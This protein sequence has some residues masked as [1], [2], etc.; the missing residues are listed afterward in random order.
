MIRIENKNKYRGNGILVC[1]PSPLGNPFKISK[2]M[3]R[4]MACDKYREWLL[5]RLETENP[6]SKAFFTLLSFY[7]DEGELV[8]ICCC[9]PLRCHA[10]VIRDLLMEV[11]ERVE[12]LK[13][14]GL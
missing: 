2:E 6:T 9:C 4:D 3:T 13:T 10:E 12:R 5:E 7:L 11:V 14:T 8:L 1:R